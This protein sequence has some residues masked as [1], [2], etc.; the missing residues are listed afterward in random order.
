MGRTTPIV[1]SFEQGLGRGLAGG[2]TSLNF[3]WKITD[4]LWD[5]EPGQRGP[6]QCE[7]QIN[8]APIHDITPGIDHNGFNRAPVYGIG[9]SNSALQG[10]PWMTNQEWQAEKNKIFGGDHGDP[11]APEEDDEG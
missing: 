9:Q 4:G 6:M 1:K 11:F 5:G 10:D 2:I 7:V 3:D 8:F